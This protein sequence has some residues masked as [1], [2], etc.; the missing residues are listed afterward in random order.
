MSKLGGGDF[1]S[2]AAGAGIN[3]LVINELA[4][5]KDPAVMQWASAVIGAAA[6]K[7]AGGSAVTGA[8]TASSDTKNNW[9]S[10]E[11]V[12]DWKNR[13]SQLYT[14]Y[15]NGDIDKDTFIE[16]ETQLDSYFIL[17]DAT[18]DTDDYFKN[19]CLLENLLYKLSLYCC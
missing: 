9:L 8:S 2:G 5:I 4:K 17:L 7:A 19:N 14:E 16:K 15:L 1:T 18:H 6:S 12:N 3:Q 11:Q 13:F 10:H